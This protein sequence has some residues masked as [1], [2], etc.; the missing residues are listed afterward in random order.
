MF[1]RPGRDRV[2]RWEGSVLPGSMG[3]GW[4][5]WRLG[6]VCADL[7]AMCGGG[8]QVVARST[9]ASAVLSLAL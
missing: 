1:E 4:A 6:G 9:S 3:E 5:R 8:V 2:D 7:A